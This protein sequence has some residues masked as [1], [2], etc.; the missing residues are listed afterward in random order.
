MADVGYQLRTVRAAN[1]SNHTWTLQVAG[2]SQN[3]NVCIPRASIMR[4]RERE[5]LLM[6]SILPFSGS[7]SRHFSGGPGAKTSCSQWRGAR[8]RSPVKGT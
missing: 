1:L 6:E 8:V 4:E 2:T 7:A 3:Y 5:R